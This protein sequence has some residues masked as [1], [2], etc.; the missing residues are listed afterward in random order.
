MT[1]IANLFLKLRTPENV[2][3]YMSKKSFSKDPLTGNMVKGFKHC[4]DLNH[5]TI[6]IFSDHFEGN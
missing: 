3:R 6:T 1:L 2:L 4:C 5:S